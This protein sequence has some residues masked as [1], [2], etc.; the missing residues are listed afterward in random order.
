MRSPGPSLPRIVAQVRSLVDRSAL[1]VL[2]GLSVLLLVLGKADMKLASF[3]VE[4]FSDAAVTVLRPLGEPIAAVRQG[5]DRVGELL[6]VHEEN[7]RL[8]EENQ[9]L[10]AWQAEAGRLA[11]QNRALR[12]MLQI[13]IPER[14]SAWTTARVVADS[15]GVF[16]RTVL[17]DA[18][19]ERGLTVGMPALAPHGLAGRVIDVGC[20]SARVLLI[21]DFNSRVPVVIERSGDQA[22]LVGDNSPEPG[23]RFLPLNPDFKVGDRVLTSG[24]GG[25]MPPGLMVGRIAAL[26]A[27]GKV[28][29]QPQVDW[30]RL[31]HLSLLRFEAVPPPPVETGLAGR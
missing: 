21:T 29:V 28:A 27:G 14:S 15:A 3:L 1:G 4:R 12:Q 7:E 9:R 25:L 13:P 20:C 22:L 16:V 6:A 11:V 19:A 5:V 17:I 23:L 24:R 8:R 26:D 30:S 18:G 10:L 2:I 31:D